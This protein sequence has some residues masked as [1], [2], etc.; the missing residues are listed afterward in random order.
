[1]SVPPETSRK[2]AALQGFGEGLGVGDD[3]RR[4]VAE[5]GAQSLGKRN[6]LGRHDVHQRPALLA[7]E[8]RFIDGGGQILV[9]DDQS[10]ARTA[11]S[12]VR[13]GGRDLRMGNGRRMHAARDES[14]NMRHVE[15]INR[16]HFIGDLRACAQNPTDADTR[17]RRR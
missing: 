9:A 4:V 2:P 10:G 17:W 13:G 14:G 6:S 11:Q 1:M 3:L 16:A 5:L 7:G 8:Y 12:F 15:D